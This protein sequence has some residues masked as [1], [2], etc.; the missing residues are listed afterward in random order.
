MPFLE[1]ARDRGGGPPLE[2]CVREAEDDLRLFLGL[3][4]PGEA[5]PAVDIE[6]DPKYPPVSS[7]PAGVADPARLL[8]GCPRIEVPFS[9]VLPIPCSLSS[10][11]LRVAVRPGDAPLPSLVKRCTAGRLE[12][13]DDCRE[14]VAGPC[15]GV[16][17]AALS[18]GFDPS[19]KSEGV[20][21]GLEAPME[22]DLLACRSSTIDMPLCGA[23]G[24]LAGPAPRR[25][26]VIVGIEDMPSDPPCCALAAFVVLA[27]TSDPEFERG[28][29][30]AAL[31]TAW[32]LA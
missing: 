13:I 6:S 4:R 3:R 31:A 11:S 18:N 29:V 8:E 9:F 15:A 7:L 24:L 23:F 2:D 19:S 12:A 20:I 30:F 26:A 1:K 32:G 25:L 17:R 5:G 22:P 21:C 10:L 27:S 14:G 28:G 16:G